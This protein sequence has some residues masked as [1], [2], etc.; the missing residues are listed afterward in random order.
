MFGPS[1][2]SCPI[3]QFEDPSSICSAVSKQ[4][5]GR[6][7]SVVSSLGIIHLKRPRISKA[8][9]QPVAVAP[10]MSDSMPTSTSLV[11]KVES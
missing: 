5:E 10:V 4:A 6:K 2:P 8:A 9:L 11:A 3:S 1:A 7:Q